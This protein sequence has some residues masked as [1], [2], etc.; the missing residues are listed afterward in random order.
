[1][2]RYFCKISFINFWKVIKAL[3]S[4]K[5]IIKDLYK[6]KRV[7]N[8][9]KYFYLFFMRILLKVDII[10]IFIKY[11]IFFKLFRDFL[12]KNNG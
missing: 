12:V 8:A 9:V 6:P 2:F 10:S 1:M 5:G 11:F 4:P 3:V 7:R